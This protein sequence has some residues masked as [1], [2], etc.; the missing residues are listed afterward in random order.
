MAVYTVDPKKN[1]VHVHDNA[2]LQTA[3]NNKRK[4]FKLSWF[5]L[6]YLSYFPDLEPTNQ[7]FFGFFFLLL[8]MQYKAQEPLKVEVYCVVMYEY[9]KKQRV[10]FMELCKKYG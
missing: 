8:F 4:K 1:V 7:L 10:N 9:K 3:G 5:I 6:P 2:R